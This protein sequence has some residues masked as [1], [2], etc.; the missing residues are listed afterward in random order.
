MHPPMFFGEQVFPG[1]DFHQAVP[2]STANQKV[3][4]R[5]PGYITQ[6]LFVVPRVDTEIPVVLQKEAAP[7]TQH[8]PRRRP[9]RPGAPA[10]LRDLPE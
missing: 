6:T 3:T 2:Y 7:R 10:G 8:P 9:R 4:V 1:T 5:A